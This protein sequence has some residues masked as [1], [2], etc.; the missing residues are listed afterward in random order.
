MALT[1]KH[2]L[3]SQTASSLI[4]MSLTRIFVT[5]GA[6][7]TCTCDNVMWLPSDTAA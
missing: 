6:S 2:K 5:A 4:R 7:I 3:V 1:I